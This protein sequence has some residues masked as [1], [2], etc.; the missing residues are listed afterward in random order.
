[1]PRF[2]HRIVDGNVDDRGVVEN[3]SE[4]H[5]PSLAHSRPRR[6]NATISVVYNA[7]QGY[8][9]RS[10]F[11]YAVRT[12]PRK[13]TPLAVLSR[14]LKDARERKGLSQRQLGI[15]AGLDQFVASTRINRYERGVHHPDPVTLQRMADVLDVPAAYLFASDDCL[16]RLILAF[17]ALPAKTQ[18]R[19]VSDLE[20]MSQI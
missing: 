5:T 15:A 4:R 8:E 7:R 6:G 12:V 17:S 16:A 18:E 20:R 3:Q 11:A 13:L 2:Q 14:R 9:S 19:V 10:G 1:M